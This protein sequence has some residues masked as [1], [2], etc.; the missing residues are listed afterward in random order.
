MKLN[1]LK[2]TFSGFKYNN[3]S[4]DVQGGM[5]NELYNSIARVTDGI[6]EGWAFRILNPSYWSMFMLFLLRNRIWV[7]FGICRNC[8]RWRCFPWLYPFWSRFALQQ[9]PTG[10]WFVESYCQKGYILCF[11]SFIAVKLAL[12][13]LRHEP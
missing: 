9:Y 5:S 2:I 1:S 12:K 3:F 11:Y 4:F 6:Y 7:N 10:N 8:N 13:F